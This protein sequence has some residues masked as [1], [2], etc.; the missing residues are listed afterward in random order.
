MSLSKAERLEGLA[1]VIRTG[2]IV[3]T[4]GL[5]FFQRKEESLEIHYFRDEDPI[6]IKAFARGL[7]FRLSV[8]DKDT[9]IREAD[10]RI[11]NVQEEALLSMKV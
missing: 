1:H 3:R 10:K 9:L 7:E 11:V 4:G 2:D 6:V 8:G 5:I